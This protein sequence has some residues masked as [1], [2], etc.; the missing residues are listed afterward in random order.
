MFTLCY[1]A[2]VMLSLNVYYAA[3]N[4]SCYYAAVNLPF[5]VYY[6]INMLLLLEEIIIYIC[7]IYNLHHLNKIHFDVI[8]YP[9]ANSHN[10]YQ[11]IF[12]NED[13]NNYIYIYIYQ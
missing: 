5:K 12:H 3:I 7:I 13:N 10:M 2:V 4:L 6:A 1:Y 9:Y 11:K 8:M